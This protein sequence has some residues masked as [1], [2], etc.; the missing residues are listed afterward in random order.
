M[1]FKPVYLNKDY[2]AGEIPRHIITNLDNILLELG[3]PGAF[4]LS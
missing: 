3:N 1:L 2:R 4:Y